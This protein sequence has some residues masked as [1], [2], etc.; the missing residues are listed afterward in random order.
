MQETV[1][2]YYPEEYRGFHRSADEGVSI[3]LRGIVRRL[4]VDGLPRMHRLLS[5]VR[6]GEPAL[7]VSREP[8]GLVLDVGCG[9][10]RTLQRLK[11]M[12]WQPYGVE[13]DPRAAT[14]G[15]ETFGL[16]VFCGQLEDARFRACVFDLVLF[17]HSL[18]HVPRPLFALREAYRRLKPRG[19]VLI[20]A[21]TARS[22]RAGRFRCRG[23]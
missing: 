14:Y 23:G 13:L 7:C 11:Q 17:H 8:P 9:E 21:P 15:I 10:G 5:A 1:L 6:V 22:F 4:L 12:G 16:D 3:R 20:H 18:E 19:G 2:H